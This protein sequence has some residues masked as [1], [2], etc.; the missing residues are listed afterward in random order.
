MQVVS[1]FFA[2]YKKNSTVFESRKFVQ[3]PTHS[4]DSPY[5][6]HDTLHFHPEHL[7]NRLPH[8]YINT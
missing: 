3:P 1:C 4:L 6:E 2:L 7:L 5:T 8:E